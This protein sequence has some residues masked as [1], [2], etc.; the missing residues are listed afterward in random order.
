MMSHFTTVTMCYNFQ[1]Q[2]CIRRSKSKTPCKFFGM[3]VDERM[4]QGAQ[5]VWKFFLK[6]LQ[7]DDKGLWAH[8]VGRQ[9]TFTHD[10]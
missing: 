3:A 7:H 5:N 2:L 10:F 6:K 9:N 1:A 4:W 8:Y